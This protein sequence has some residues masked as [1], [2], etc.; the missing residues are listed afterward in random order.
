M[1]NVEITDQQLLALSGQ[2]AFSRGK[3]YFQQGLVE[4]WQKNGQTITADVQGTELYRVTL[5]HNNQRFEGS[6]D[7]PASEGFDF[8]KHCVAV[9]MLYRQEVGEQT[10]LGDGNVD[11]RIQAY[12]NKLDHQALVAQLLDIITSDRGL[13]Q[14]WS[15]KADIA[16]NKM[17][18]K[19]I[20]KLITAAIPYNKHLYRYSQVRNYFD[21]I[22]PVIDLLEGQ[23]EQLG[24]EKTLSLV[25]YALQRLSRALETIDDSGGFRLE[26]EER[27]QQLHCEIVSKL[28]WD[29]PRLVAYLLSIEDSDCADLY[30]AIPDAYLTCLGD[31]GETLI[32]KEYQRRWDALPPLS[33]DADW[34]D[35]STYRM[36][37]YQ[38]RSRAE[39]DDDWQT[40][41]S[42][43]QKTA[44]TDVD[45]LE[46]CQLCHDHG[47]IDQAERWLSEAK[48]LKIG[49]K[50]N[51]YS[52]FNV[53]RME[54][55]LLLSHDNF[56][57]A[58]E[59]QWSIYQ[60]TLELED[61]ERVLELAEMSHSD[62]NYFER[63]EAFLLGRIE[64]N[65][66]QP[67]FHR[68]ADDLVALYL[69]EEE[70]LDAL[71]LV[72]QHQVDESSLLQ[73]AQAFNNKP[74]I[75]I[76]L[77]A[78]LADGYVSQ[79]NNNAYHKAVALILT[80][81]SIADDAGHKALAE[82]MLTDF[83]VRFKAKRNFIKFLNEAL[84]N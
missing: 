43:L 18:V 9:A 38:L 22:G 13:K 26:L 61:Y 46:L 63:A 58:L 37:Q 5:I 10:R 54:I 28:V 49:D 66:H 57:Q 72:R 48:R 76:P 34:D 19:A 62:E 20:K 33:E 42:L 23:S 56:Q 3:D 36:L 41:I 8:C 81:I 69:R 25:D 21:K 60:Q 83:R 1:D 70:Y 44:I 51:R 82:Q 68:Y 73:V 45:F 14:T 7:C 17:D 47:D 32:H 15:I 27:L 12:L 29:K 6:C 35:E 79:G 40:V 31:D 74:D 67:W 64:T 39:R 16:L 75:A 2:G 78:L 77:Y 4:H 30:A 59:I 71:A 80:V 52:G 55:R 50:R 65:A 11:Q 84:T 53:E 24:A